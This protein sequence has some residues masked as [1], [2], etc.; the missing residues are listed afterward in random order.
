VLG[1]KTCF[2]QVPRVPEHSKAKP[3]NQPTQQKKS[4][5]KCLL[6][7]TEKRKNGENR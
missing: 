1:F 6:K 7:S 2:G 3:N 5:K 4:P